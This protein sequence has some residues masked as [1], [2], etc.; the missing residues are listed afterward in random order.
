MTII[1]QE[2]NFMNLS[3]Y[4]SDYF[5]KELKIPEGSLVAS[6]LKSIKT[7]IYFFLLISTVTC[8]YAFYSV[9]QNVGIAIVAAFIFQF[10]F[11][12]IYVVLFSTIRK[13]DF[14]RIVKNKKTPVINEDINGILLP[15]RKFYIDELDKNNATKRSWGN[16]IFRII[17]LLFLGAGPAY[18]FGIM[19]HAPFTTQY[20]QDAKSAFINEQIQSHEKKLNNSQLSIQ[21]ELDSLN[22]VKQGY[23]NT[24]D[25][26]QKNPDIN[27]Y[28]KEDIAWLQSRIVNFDELNALKIQND[29]EKLLQ[30][31]ANASNYAEALRSHFQ[32]ADFFYLRSKVTIRHY[33]VTF[34]VA[35]LLFLY[36]LLNPFLRRY[37]LIVNNAPELDD[38]LEKHYEKLIHQ[39]HEKFVYDYQKTSVVK[40]LEESLY[41]EDF[42]DAQ[43]NH[44]HEILSQIKNPGGKYEDPAVKSKHKH[45]NRIFVEKGHLGK[46]LGK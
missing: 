36:L 28:Y 13:S 35:V 22:K 10:I 34:Y 24:I 38:L 37:R 43:K 33:Y 16:V 39:N 20:Y 11:L 21:K 45:D 12:M 32:T 9:F 23:L 44:F 1:R 26:L 7:G 18:F 29:K 8:L 6:K 5:F 3:E 42:S 2:R 19:L 25:S 17:L 14:Q 46:Y 27:G 15:V 31:E 40:L 4:I 30:G 41:D